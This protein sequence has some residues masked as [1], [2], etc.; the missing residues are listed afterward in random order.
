MVH[1]LSLAL[2]GGGASAREKAERPPRKPAT[3]LKVQ[4]VFT[5]YLGEKKVSS[6]PYT[7]SVSSDDPR[8][9]LRMGIEVPVTVQGK[10]GQPQNQYRNVGTNLDC[11]AEALEDGRF[12]PELGL[13]QSSVYAAEAGGKA[14]GSAPGDSHLGNQPLFRSFSSSANL[15]LRDGQTAQYTAATDPV[16]GEVLKVGVTLNVVK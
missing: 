5:K 9:R 16:S 15:V 7:L 8:S 10:E 12:K 3:P 13:E 4:V 14:Q 11:R 6:L 2:L 1:L